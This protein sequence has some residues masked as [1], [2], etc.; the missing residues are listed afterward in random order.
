MVH[1]TAEQKQ[2]L[3]IL[4]QTKIM[5]P[6]KKWITIWSKK[7]KQ[8]FAGCAFHTDELYTHVAAV[9]FI[10]SSVQCNWLNNLSK[11]NYRNYE[12][13]VTEAECYNHNH[14]SLLFS[15]LKVRYW[16]NHIAPCES[17]FNTLTRTY[18]FLWMQWLGG[19]MITNTD[20][21]L[22]AA[23]K[24]NWRSSIPNSFETTCR[25]WI[26]WYNISYCYLSFGSCEVSINHRT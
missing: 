20:I 16:V 18:Q 6:S 10:R 13:K 25:W 2:C 12:L 19:Y 7:C 3:C 24:H 14:S 23:S 8:I 17:C 21:L 15:H 22:F 26:G 4:C 1:L 11:K 5:Q 9:D